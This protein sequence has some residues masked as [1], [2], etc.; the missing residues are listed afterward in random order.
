[1]NK[2][3]NFINHYS[4]EFE[5]C[6]K[7]AQSHTSKFLDIFSCFFDDF[8]QYHD[9][10]LLNSVPEFTSIVHRSG[11]ALIAA[12]G[13]IEAFVNQIMTMEVNWAFWI[14]FFDINPED[15]AE[16]VSFNLCSDMMTCPCDIYAKLIVDLERHIT[17][18]VTGALVVDVHQ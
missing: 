4:K 1:M 5:E 14:L 15:V 13:T 3:W 7:T 17:E 2:K 6:V 11:S 12:C 18:A 16:V 8:V 10:E 9:I